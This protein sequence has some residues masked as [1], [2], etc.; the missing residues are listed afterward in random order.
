MFYHIIKHIKSSIKL[1]H[2]ELDLTNW[3]MLKYLDLG[4]AWHRTDHPKIPN[5]KL[6]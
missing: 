3:F 4:Q 1:E 6:V 2:V 5:L